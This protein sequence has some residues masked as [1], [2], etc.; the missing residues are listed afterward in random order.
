MTEWSPAAWGE[1]WKQLAIGDSGF[2][3][4]S[5]HNSLQFLKTKIKDRGELLKLGLSRTAQ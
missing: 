2:S 1:Q 3:V 4:W 5:S